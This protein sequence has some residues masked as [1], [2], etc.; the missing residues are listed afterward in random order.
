[1]KPQK[2]PPH[3]ARRDDLRPPERLSSGGIHGRGNGRVRPARDDRG[4]RGDPAVP[5]VPHRPD[6]SRESPRKAPRRRGE[7]GPGLQHRRGAPGVRARVPGAVPARRLRHPLRL[8]RPFGA[9]AHAAQ[10]HGQAG[11]ARPGHPHTR[12]RR[13]A[14][15]AGHRR[16]VPALSPLR[17]ARLGGDRKRNRREIDRPGYG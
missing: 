14:R 5:R 8:F 3:D 15:C 2:V 11:R 1:M 17:Q 13:G 7:V 4:H 6:R 10:G 12:L 16:G 9:G